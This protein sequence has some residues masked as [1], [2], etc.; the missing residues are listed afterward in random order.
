MT[1]Q[2]PGAGVKGVIAFSFRS[3]YKLVRADEACGRLRAKFHGAGAPY[4]S[5]TFDQIIMN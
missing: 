1:T 3:H 4:N 5:L 2:L